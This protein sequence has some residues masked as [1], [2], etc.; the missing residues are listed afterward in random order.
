MEK[1]IKELAELHKEKEALSAQIEKLQDLEQRYQD[2]FSQTSVHCETLTTLQD[3]LVT[4]KLI[5]EKLK[6]SMEKFGLNQDVL[7]GDVKVFVDKLLNHLELRKEIMSVIKE[8]QLLE[9]G[10]ETSNVSDA[11]QETDDETQI[12]FEKL[13]A[14]M[15]V[16]YQQNETLQAE[17]AKMQVDVSTVSSQ[18]NSLTIQ[19]TAL[20]LANSQLVAEKEEVNIKKVVVL[21]IYHFFH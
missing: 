7:E 12:K 14:E 16:I 5:N 1:Q 8:K 4:Q 9:D 21:F 17:N 19:Q 20:Q 3:D 11:A 18:I 13:I 10:A 2:L 15:S 6:T